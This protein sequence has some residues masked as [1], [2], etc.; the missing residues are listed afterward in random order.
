MVRCVR[1][2]NQVVR[3]APP[4]AVCRERVYR[5]LELSAHVHLAVGIDRLDYTKGIAEKFL[6]VERLFEQH[7]PL[8]GRFVLVQVAEPSRECLPAYRA[9]HAQIVDTA[10]RI[11]ARFGAGAIARSVCS[12]RI[13]NRPRCISCFAPPASVMSAVCTTA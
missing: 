8:R 4:V 10:A 1:Q 7:P 12:R 13:T 5:D 6:A 3:V 11:N 2:K 9:A